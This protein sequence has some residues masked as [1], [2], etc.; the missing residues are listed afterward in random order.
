M[1]YESEYH[2]SHVNPEKCEVNRVYNKFFLIS[3]SLPIDK[4]VKRTQYNNDMIDEV[5]LFHNLSV[6]N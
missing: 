2:L 4:N 6:L 5:I 3:L 1:N